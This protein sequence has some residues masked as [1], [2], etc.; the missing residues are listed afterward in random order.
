L[1]SILDATGWV[2]IRD[3]PQFP[4]KH[5]PETW[6]PVFL[7]D[8]RGTR[9]RGDHAGTRNLSAMMIQAEFIAL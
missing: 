5:D 6:T 1:S 9:L 2:R 7:C 3:S 8:K 4:K